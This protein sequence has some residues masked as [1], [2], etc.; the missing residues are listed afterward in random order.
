LATGNQATAELLPSSASPLDVSWCGW[1][2]IPMTG[3]FPIRSPEPLWSKRCKTR[4]SFYATW[5]SWTY[6]I[7]QSI[8]DVS[9]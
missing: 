9:L 6:A 5:T 8:N 7:T 3:E 1:R 2:A 4:K